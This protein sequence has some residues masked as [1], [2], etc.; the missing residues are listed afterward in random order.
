MSN[1]K[2]YNLNNLKNAVGGDKKELKEM[3]ALFVDT[4]SE[5]LTEIETGIKEG[6]MAK[7]AS[8]AHSA[9]S[10]IDMLEVKSSFIK[11]KEIE[12]LA[13]A[14][15]ELEKIPRLFDAVKTEMKQVIEGLKREIK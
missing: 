6:D 2:L 14:K 8:A 12:V 4:L 9:K 10:N 5:L 15:E 1:I 3:I 13:K 7:V 11:M